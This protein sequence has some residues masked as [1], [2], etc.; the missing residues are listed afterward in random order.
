MARALWGLCGAAREKPDA[1]PQANVAS[2]PR[3]SCGSDDS[4]EKRW[5]EQLRVASTSGVRMPAVEQRLYER[6][7]RAGTRRQLADIHGAPHKQSTPIVPHGESTAEKAMVFG[8]SQCRVP[9]AAAILTL[10]MLVLSG[11]TT[12]VTEEDY[13]S[14]AAGAIDEGQAA[15]EELLQLRVE[16][17]EGRRSY[18][19]VAN[20]ADDAAGLHDKLRKRVER[21]NEPPEWS[22]SKRYLVE[23]FAKTES[24][25]REFAACYRAANTYCARGEAMTNSAIAALRASENAAPTVITREPGVVE[26][27]APTRREPQYVC[28][29]AC[30]DFLPASESELPERQTLNLNLT[31]LPWQRSAFAGH[32]RLS[33]L[34]NGSEIASQIYPFSFEPGVNSTLPLQLSAWTN[35]AVVWRLGIEGEALAGL[36]FEVGA[37]STLFLLRHNGTFSGRC[38]G[39]IGPVALEDPIF[40]TH[41]LVNVTFTVRSEYDYRGDCT[42]FVP[43]HDRDWGISWDHDDRTNDIHF[44]PGSTEIDGELSMQIALPHDPWDIP[45]EGRRLL[46]GTVDAWSITSVNSSHVQIEVFLHNGDGVTVSCE[47]CELG[48]RYDAFLKRPA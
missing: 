20:A 36:E 43:N 21:A 25:F 37:D 18:D 26:D 3:P 6:I 19:D 9:R 47:G 5:T 31:V 35:A 22:E 13:L 14:L 38:T 2:F 39:C 10:A 27:S 40:P 42:L 15:T 28:V 24:A 17:E 30:E 12:A 45:L 48:Q 8:F 41:E 32:A 34:A 11:C 29:G 4:S 44:C 1:S 33:A 7:G 16:L 23:F 46:I